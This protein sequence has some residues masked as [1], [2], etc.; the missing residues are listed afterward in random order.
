MKKLLTDLCWYAAGVY[1]TALQKDS[2]MNAFTSDA[3][4]GEL[5]TELKMNGLKRA[6]A[7]S[8]LT[9]TVAEVPSLQV[10]LVDKHCY[11]VYISVTYYV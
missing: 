4:T 8:S 7:Q 11:N 1:F 9:S 3:R 6:R 5:K 2:R 10:K